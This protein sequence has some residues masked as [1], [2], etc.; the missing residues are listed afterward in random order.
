MA[1]ISNEL[2][3]E[4]NELSRK[5]KTVGLTEEEKQRQQVLRA[6]YIKAFRSGFKQHLQNI[7]VVDEKG[8][9]ITPSKIKKLKK[10]N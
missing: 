6:E 8:N 7:K 1:E 2:I 9:D 5:S 4:I 10:H 3:N